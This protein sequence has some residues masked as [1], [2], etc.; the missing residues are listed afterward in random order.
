[1]SDVAWR[2]EQK[3]KTTRIEDSAGW[4]LIPSSGYTIPKIHLLCN[5]IRPHSK[6]LPSA[7]P[8]YPYVSTDH[9][10]RTITRR[11]VK[12][13]AR[14]AQSPAPLQ[15]QTSGN[16]TLPSHGIPGATL[17]FPRG[18]TGSPSGHEMTLLHKICSVKRINLTCQCA[19][20]R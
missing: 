18:L 9:T 14:L 19:H 6:G 10:P 1:M 17:R 3:K 13:R 4:K 20:A 15:T 7:N 2:E 11:L 12:P 5:A 16:S 8:P